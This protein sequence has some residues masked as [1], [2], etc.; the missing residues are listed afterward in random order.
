MPRP[1]ADKLQIEVVGDTR[2]AKAVG[3]PETTDQEV[4]GEPSAEVRVTL[5]AVAEVGVVV[6]G[7]ALTVT[8]TF[9]ETD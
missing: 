8:I 3:C 4:V 5:G 2:H 9:C 6:T 1:V 7:A